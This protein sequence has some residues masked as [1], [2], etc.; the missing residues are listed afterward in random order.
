MKLRKPIKYVWKDQQIALFGSE[1]EWLVML[2]K[3]AAKDE[4]AW[5]G[6]GRKAG[7]HIW[8]YAKYKLTEW[9]KVDYGT[10]FSHDTYIILNTRKKH[11]SDVSACAY[12]TY[13][14]IVQV[15]HYSTTC[16]DSVRMCL[17]HTYMYVHVCMSLWPSVVNLSMPTVVL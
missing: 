8:R 6:F 12:V 3:E 14:E 5:K 1:S 13:I 16:K 11:K 9:P 10:F 4:P 15:Y 17:T 2:N 7:I